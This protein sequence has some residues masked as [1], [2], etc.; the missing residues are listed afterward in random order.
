MK[1]VF[2]DIWKYSADIICITTNGTIKNN[3]EGVMGAGIALQAKKK[4]LDLPAILGNTLKIYGNH[5]CEFKNYAFF[6]VK[7]NWWEKADLELIERSALELANFA[8]L[9]AD[10]IYVLPRPGCGNGG[11]KWEEVKEIIE[12]ILPDNVHVIDLSK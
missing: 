11:L 4:N 8:N 1:T 7:H 6:P 12:L 3:G 9:N 2:G 10:K 5:F